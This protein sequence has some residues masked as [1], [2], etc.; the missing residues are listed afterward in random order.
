[1][2]WSR[3]KSKWQVSRRSKIE[4]KTIHNGYFNANEETK[5]AHASDT[6][7][8]TLIANGENGYKLNF[9]DDETEVWAKVTHIRSEQYIIHFYFGVR[10]TKKEKEAML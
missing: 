7:A 3:S 10:K 1:M 8:R 6:L 5:A 4:R 9:P 2:Y